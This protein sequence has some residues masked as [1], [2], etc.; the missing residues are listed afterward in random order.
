MACGFFDDDDIVS[1]RGDETP[2]KR[3]PEKVPTCSQ[4]G[5]TDKCRNPNIPVSGN[6]GR[7]ILLVLEC[8]SEAEDA[9]GKPWTG[10]TGIALKELIRKETGLDVLRDCWTAFALT[11]RPPAGDP[12][13]LQIAA[14][15]KFLHHSIKHLKPQL[16]IPFGRWAVEGVSGDRLKGRLSGMNT[17]DWA[18]EQIPDQKWGLYVCP[19]WAPWQLRLNDSRRPDPVVRRQLCQHIKAAVGLLDGCVER[20]NDE[21]HVHVLYNVADAREVLRDLAHN[22]G[23]PVAFDYETTG[24]KPYRPGHKIF[25]ASVSDG[26]KAWAFP[27]FDDARF[28]ASWRTLM[29]SPTTPKIAHNAKFEWLWTR[30]IEGY[31]PQRLLADTM[32][33]AHVLH[34]QKPVGLKFRAYCDFGVAGYDDEVDPYLETTKVE[35]ARYGANGFNLIAKAPLDKL[36]LYNGMDS[37]YTYWLWEKQQDLLTELTRKGAAFLTATSIR[38]AEAEFNG[39]CLNREG[40]AQQRIHLTERMTRLEKRISAMSVE[41]GWDRPTPLRP[42]AP[43][44]IAHLVHDLMGYAV[45]D[46]TES[47]KAA[48]DKAAMEKIDLPIMGRIMEWKKWQKVRDTYIKGFEVESTDGLIHPFFNL[49]NVVSYRSSSDSPNFQNVPKRDKRTA[50]PLRELLQ[51]HEGQRLME[52]DYKAIEVGISACYNKDPALIKYITDPSTDMHRDTGEELFM[53]GRGELTKDERSVAKNGF[54]F[55]AFYGSYFEQMAPDLWQKMPVET[56]RHLQSKGVRNLEDFTEHV[57]GIE[58]IFWGNRFPVYA[59][60]K[61]D[62]YALYERRGYVESYTGFRYYGPMKRNEVTN[63]AI[64]GSAFHCLLRTFWKMTDEMKKAKMRSRTIGQVHDSMVLSVHP[65]EEMEVDRMVWYWGSQ[66]IREAWDWI[67]VPLTIEKDRSAVGGT[68][69]EMESCGALAF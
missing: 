60:W 4:C 43:E 44:D 62:Q 33:A 21:G 23:A 17:Q 20:R 37:L 57:R 15:R 45:T 61:K 31:W 9:R 16:V 47:G 51:P 46:R 19:T 32:L 13:G 63:Y 8:P 34:N 56:R 48:M 35:E 11:C 29:E 59:Q 64:Q 38:L 53:R 50:G 36:L 55:P 18:G 66:E 28:R 42:N 54:V 49:H 67:I 30:Q 3:A 1:T 25:T 5:L 68:W 41:S 22:T 12:N 24:R 6:G 69:N 27:F 65:D 40:A 7:G 52:Y 58:E 10:E 2:T 26:R 39:L 14:C